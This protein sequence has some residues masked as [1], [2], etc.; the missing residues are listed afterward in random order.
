MTFFGEIVIGK[1][2]FVFYRTYFKDWEFYDI[3]LGP[4]NHTYDDPCTEHLFG[5]LC[6]ESNNDLNRLKDNGLLKELPRGGGS[7]II[8]NSSS[9]PFLIPPYLK[10]RPYWLWTPEERIWL[11]M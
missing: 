8:A 1:S 7:V 9:M 11:N 6:C 10:T 2:T 5:K 3:G 4:V